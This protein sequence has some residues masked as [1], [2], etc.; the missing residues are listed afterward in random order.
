MKSITLNLANVHIYENNI[1]NTRLL[2]EGNENVKFE[3]NV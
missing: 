1:A 3:L 2:L